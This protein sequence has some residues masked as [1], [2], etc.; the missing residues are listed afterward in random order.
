MIMRV[1]VML[2][3][4]QFQTQLDW[5]IAEGTQGKNVSQEIFP[6]WYN[7]WIGH[8]VVVGLSPEFS[9]ERSLFLFSRFHQCLFQ[10]ISSRKVNTT[11]K[12]YQ[13]IL[14]EQFTRSI[15]YLREIPHRK[16][17]SLFSVSQKVPNL[18]F[19]AISYVSHPI[20]MVKTIIIFLV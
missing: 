7:S 16:A 20:N 8:F 18:P 3:V 13:A 19:I 10:E 6:M 1:C 14:L 9:I 2:L 11:P 12:V 17:S 5:V 15:D 4:R